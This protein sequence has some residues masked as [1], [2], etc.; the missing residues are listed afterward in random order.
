M[1]SEMMMAAFLE[2]CEMV[3]TTKEREPRKRAKN[4][5][6]ISVGRGRASAILDK[7]QTPLQ[8]APILNI[9]DGPDDRS[10]AELIAE[11]LSHWK[12]ITNV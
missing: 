9:M 8:A 5:T 1:L 2:L 7:V 3:M 11:R 12:S 10:R 4:G 6:I